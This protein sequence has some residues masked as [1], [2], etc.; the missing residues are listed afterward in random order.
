MRARVLCA[1][2]TLLLIAVPITFLLVG[3]GGGGGSGGSS[4]TGNSGAGTVAVSIADNPT[5]DYSKILIKITEVSLLPGPVVI[6][7]SEEGKEINLLEH[8]DNNDYLLKVNY[9]VPARAYNK[10]RVKI[11][12][13]R[14]EP[15]DWTAAVCT[16]NIKLPSNKIDL[17]PQGT[18]KVTRGG[19]LAIR[20]DFDAN[21]AFD[22]HPAGNSGKCIFRPVIFVDIG[23]GIPVQKCPQVIAGTIGDITYDNTGQAE[24]F[25]LERKDNKDNVN[26]HLAADVVVFDGNFVSSSVLYSE[27]QVKVV[28]KFDEHLV[29]QGTTVVV[30]DVFTIKGDVE[31]DINFVDGSMNVG[32][33]TFNPFPGEEILDPFEVEVE[34]GDT[35]ILI[36]CDQELQPEDIQAGMTARVIGKFI[37][38]D[39]VLRAVAVFLKPREISGTLLSWNPTADGN[40]LI[41][42]VDGVTVYVPRMSE[43]N[44][45]YNKFYPIYLEND[46]LVPL[47]LLCDT[48]QVRAVLDPYASN[49]LVAEEVRVQAEPPEGKNGTVDQNDAPV[50][51]LE[52]G[53]RVYFLPGA[54]I[55]DERPGGADTSVDDLVQGDNLFYHG[56]NACAGDTDVDSY[57]FIVQVVE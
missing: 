6:F 40:Y 14:A 1:L 22:L 34:R 13:I 35:S 10:I 54:T 56:L 29:F 55:V 15:K 21:T 53:E 27:L 5:D 51:V 32:Q 16:N 45:P 42:D 7:E 8:R 43:P 50:L 3:C 17:N 44:F 11:S 33:F 30:G 46:G 26:V 23:E 2:F 49:P 19:T 31:S 39:S 25:V 57:A 12:E 9:D 52:N 37:A 41:M 20:L 18:F 36:G 28:G 38:G 24:D 4:V 47:G 48:R